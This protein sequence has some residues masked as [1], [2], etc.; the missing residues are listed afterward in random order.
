MDHLRYPLIPI[1][2]LKPISKSPLPINLPYPDMIRENTEN[3]RKPK[4][5]NL[6][7][8]MSP[9]CNSIS[10]LHLPSCSLYI[11]V[12]IRTNPCGWFKL[13]GSIILN[14]LPVRSPKLP[15]VALV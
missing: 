3:Y 6:M 11:T 8:A 12:V 14:V 4:K 1:K 13:H 7:L 15:R 9:L 10:P 5:C 2:D